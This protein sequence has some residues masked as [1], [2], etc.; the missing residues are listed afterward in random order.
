MEKKH[1]LVLVFIEQK[2]A[3]YFRPLG[4]PAFELPA[5]DASFDGKICC[6]A[7]ESVGLAFSL[8]LCGSI[9]KTDS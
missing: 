3:Q 8:L 1:L 4:N 6:R 2:S 5:T 9:K 7:S